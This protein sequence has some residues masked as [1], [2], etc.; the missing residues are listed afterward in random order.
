VSRIYGEPTAAKRNI[1]NADSVT[2][3]GDGIRELIKVF[4]I[5]FIEYI[6]SILYW[7]DLDKMSFYCG[8][9]RADSDCINSTI[10]YSQI[11]FRFHFVIRS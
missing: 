4:S 9:A 5:Y 2:Q 6:I 3:D 10:Y 7:E 11:C 1:L 8:C